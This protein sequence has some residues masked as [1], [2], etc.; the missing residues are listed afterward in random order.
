MLLSFVLV[1][2]RLRTAHQ[3]PHLSPN[4]V[5]CSATPFP[6]VPFIALSYSFPPAVCGGAAATM[7]VAGAAHPPQA[8]RVPQ[9]PP[10]P[11]TLCCVSSLRP[12]VIGFAGGTFLNYFAGLSYNAS[13]N[14]EVWLGGRMLFSAA[15]R[16]I[17]T[18]ASTCTWPRSA[19]PRSSCAPDNVSCARLLRSS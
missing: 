11:Q 9:N 12:L 14:N 7:T 18:L 6:F 8:A 4:F 3:D 19:V 16:P 10:A 15:A 13:P 5:S 2:L 17:A 1:L